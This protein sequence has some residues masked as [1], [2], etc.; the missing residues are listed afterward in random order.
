M[1]MDPFIEAEEVAGHSVKRC[2][3][4]FEVSRAAFYQR[5]K[6]IPSARDV[7]DA[8]LTEKIREIH[9]ESD[10][11]YGSPRVHEELRKRD[12]A[13]GRRRVRRLMRRAG[14]E[15]RAKKRWRTT[16]IPTPRWSGRQGSDPTRLRSVCRDRPPLRR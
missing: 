6:D 5:R 15:G 10:G 14:L 1:K 4:L 12:V 16:T 9:A 13:C 7:S 3:E 2:C 11:T 8:E